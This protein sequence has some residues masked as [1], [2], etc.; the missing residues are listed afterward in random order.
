MDE[1]HG[2]RDAGCCSSSSSAPASSDVSHY[3]LVALIT[4]FLILLTYAAFFYG[5]PAIRNCFP[6][7]SQVCC[8]D[9]DRG[10]CCPPL[11]NNFVTSD[12]NMSAPNQLTVFAGPGGNVITTFSGTGIAHLNN[13]VVTASP[14]NLASS[15]EVEGI[16]ITS[17]MPGLTGDVISAPGTVQ[18]SLIP[19]GVTP[20]TYT[21]ATVTVDAKGRVTAATN[22]SG[23]LPTEARAGNVAFVD[24]V[25]GNDGTGMVN[26]PPFKT[27]TA[28]LNAAASGNTVYV[29]PGQYNEALSVPTNVSLIGVNAQSVMVFQ[30]VA[31]STTLLTVRDNSQIANLTLQLTATSNVQLV[32]ISYTGTSTAT[33][34]VTNVILNVFNVTGPASTIGVLSGGTGAPSSSSW[35]CLQLSKINVA[36]ASL[37]TAYGINSTTTNTLVA[38]DLNITVASAP[39]SIGVFTQNG[40]TVH[41]ANSI[42]N[43]MT[44]D[45]SQSMGTTISLGHGT[46]RLFNSN[47]NGNGFTSSYSSPVI[48]GEPGI[49]AL[50]P[51]IRYYYPGTLGSSASIVGYIVPN[52]CLLFGMFVQAETASLSSRTADTWTVYVNGVAS[53]M[54]VSMAQATSASLVTSSIT[55]TK[56]QQVSVQVTPGTGNIGPNNVA[57]TLAFY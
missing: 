45:I 37:G 6:V 23:S 34:M 41:I 26:G 48:F 31:T 7:K 12:T 10:K 24:Q 15:S 8:R 42:I 28:A 57:V 13:G 47:A 36:G 50:G 4:F 40:S 30:T 54:S 14:V 5:S 53:I 25:N 29:Y 16:L 49:L 1:T 3:I 32:G 22:G 55:V 11:P 52:T 20:G 19:S 38:S 21:N 35:I 44:A 51:T 56:G 33:S 2:S 46:T 18:T 9:E 39:T 17:S 43:G 27:I